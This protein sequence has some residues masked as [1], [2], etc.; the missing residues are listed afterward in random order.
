[1]SNY[2]KELEAQVESLKS[3]LEKERDWNDFMNKRRDSQKYRRWCFSFVAKTNTLPT[4]FIEKNKLQYS[5]RESV[6][7][8]LNDM[9]SEIRNVIDEVILEY[10]CDVITKYKKQMSNESVSFAISIELFDQ[11]KDSIV[12][13]NKLELALE[14]HNKIAR[15]EVLNDFKPH[16]VR[17]VDESILPHMYQNSKYVEK[18]KETFAWKNTNEEQR[19]SD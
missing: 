2:E 13:C 10:Y 11:R 6:F 17:E 4:K 15:L 8:S 19:T 3:A 7:E 1:M 5:Y 14:I 18:W 16:S 12:Y 9:R